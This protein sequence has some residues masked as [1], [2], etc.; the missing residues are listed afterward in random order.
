SCIAARTASRPSASSRAPTSLCRGCA[1]ARYWAGCSSQRRQTRR[2]F[3]L[4]SSARAASLHVIAEENY[5]LARGGAVFAARHPAAPRRGVDL[6]ELGAGEAHQLAAHDRALRRGIPR[7][8]AP[9]R[10]RRGDGAVDRARLPNPPGA[11]AL[12][13]PCRAR[14]PRHDRGDPD[15][16]LPRSLADSPA[17][18]GDDAGAAMPRRGSVL[19]RPSAMALA[20]GYHGSNLRIGVDIG[21]TKIEALA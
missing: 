5:C 15:L 17:V 12:Y 14:P 10:D 8:A 6:L 13:P 18:G 21:G 1:R 19:A 20:R 9:A 4:R 2:C 7:A 11:R 3:S 16:R